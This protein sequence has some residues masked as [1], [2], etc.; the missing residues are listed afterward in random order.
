VA[1]V[2]V[3]LVL[4]DTWRA[5]SGWCGWL[6][7]VLTLVVVVFHV[8]WATATGVIVTHSARMSSCC[9][10]A[11]SSVGAV[12]QLSST[13]RGAEG[14]YPCGCEWVVWGAVGCAHC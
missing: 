9:L 6:W 3:E 13:E 4:N 2:L 14:Q 5:V 11:H 7:A 12:W 10:D 1:A 8:P